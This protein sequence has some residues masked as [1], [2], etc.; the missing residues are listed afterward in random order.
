MSSKSEFLVTV[1]YREPSYELRAGAKP[2]PFVASFRI[3]AETGEEAERLAVEEF[4]RQEQSSFVSWS[5]V[6]EKVESA[7]AP[8]GEGGA[9]SIS[10]G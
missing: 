9:E 5:R 6:I 10:P 2:K 4:Q 3:S 8:R 1:T 7:P